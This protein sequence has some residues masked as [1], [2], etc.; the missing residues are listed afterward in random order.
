MRLVALRFAYRL[1]RSMGRAKDLMGRADLRLVTTGWDPSEV[2][3]AKRLCRLVWSEWTHSDRE[4]DKARRAEEGFFRELE[5]TDGIKVPSIEQRAT[6]LETA[7][8][9][10]TKGEVQLA[11]LR[12]L[13]EQAGDEVNLLWLKL[14]LEGV[15]EA[16][17]MAELSGRDVADF[18]A[19]ARRRNRAVQRLLANDRGVDWEE[20][21]P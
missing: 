2:S 21:E 12:V 20:E 5:A 19:A 11:K 18:Y 6:E 16:T 7:R 3:L 4:T 10:Q 17:R 9:T 14:Q 15:T 13:F 8:E 1:T